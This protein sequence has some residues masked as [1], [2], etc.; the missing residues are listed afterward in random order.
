M[1]KLILLTLALLISSTSIFAVK[2]NG[3]IQGK[4]IEKESMKALP[5]ATV[6]ITDT[7][8]KI[9]TGTITSEDGSFKI[10]NLQNGVVNIKVSFIGFRDTTLSVKIEDLSTT[11]DI[12]TI[13]LSADILNLKS[14]VVTAK[15]PVIEQKLDKL[16]MNVSEAVTTQGSNALEILR[17]APGVSIDPSGNI[18]LN[19]SPV[20]VWIDGR[21]S[22]LSGQEL[23]SLLSGTDGS[24][25]DKIEIISHPSARYDA[26][27]GG[28]I[29]NIKTKKNFS[30]GL[31]GSVRSSYNS[32]YDQMFYHAADGS[33]NLNYRTDKSN[34]S[35]TYSPRYNEHFEKITTLTDMGSARVLEGYTDMSLNIMNHGI[36]V[37]NDFFINKTNIFGFIVN[38]LVSDVKSFTRPGSGN[39]FLINNINTEITN[40]EIEGDENFDFINTNLNY[41][42]SFRNSQ[43]LTLNADYG[44]YDITKFNAQEN[45]FYDNNN[46]EIRDPQRFRSNSSQY[47]N[48]YSFKADYEFTIL[49]KYRMESGL[50]WARSITD[51]D[52][53]REDKLNNTWTKNQIL[54]S[55][56]KY[57]EDISAAYVSA[58]RQ[59][60]P[61]ISIKAGLRIEITQAQGDWISADTL[62]TKSYIDLFPTL[63]IGYNPNKNLRLGLSYTLRVKRPNFRQLNPFRIYLDALSSVEGNPD[64]DPQYN[65]QITLSLGFKQYF[66]ISIAGQYTNN[67]IIQNPYF[68][69]QTGEKMIIWDNFGKQNFTGLGLSVTEYPITKWLNL[70][71]NIFLAHL[72][73]SSGDYKENSFFTQGFISTTFLLPLNYKVELIGTYQSGLPYGYF[74]VR[75]TGDITIGIKK[76]FLDN[77]GNA[78][79]TFSDVLNTQNTR[80]SLNN[81]PINSYSLDNNQKTQKITLTLSF[82]FGQSKASK[83]RKVGELEE[84]SRVGTSN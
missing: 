77:R 59:L 46:V 24:T 26:E 4:V 55:V 67:A 11:K 35:I 54:S 5:Y 65:N 32:A 51:N 36:R 45:L 25:I 17:K 66:N 83:A 82:R 12:G 23:E 2:N 44:Y 56:F 62:T 69:T 79:L 42:K 60:N 78:S 71:S 34:T 76:G 84:G 10:A 49:K 22:N 74:K 31:N 20:Q 3:I 18:L 38:G 21:P 9:I 68:N 58:A 75:P 29:I 37:S 41:S 33:L 52:M 1:R 61:K 43:E 28:G 40:S 47:I 8:N 63:F 13:L 48:I 27:G 7:D 14:V 53:L 39:K 30:K 80:I 6:S 64:L 16:V 70:N 19:G 73:N 15:V 72:T 57:N 50:K 81:G